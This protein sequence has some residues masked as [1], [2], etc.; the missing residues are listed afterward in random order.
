MYHQGVLKER[1]KELKNRKVM[2]YDGT[3]KM[4]G[5]MGIKL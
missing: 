1:E 3:G 2:S 4:F 5:D